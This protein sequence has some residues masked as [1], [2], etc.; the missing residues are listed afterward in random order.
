V[1]EST[2]PQGE[3]MGLGLAEVMAEFGAHSE[4]ELAPIGG[5]IEHGP[6]LARQRGLIRRRIASCAACGLRAGCSAP[7]PFEAPPGPICAVIGEAPGADED[8]RGRPF[9]GPSGK[10]LRAML[11]V[12]GIEPDEVLWANTASCRPPEN[13]APTGDEMAACRGNLMDQLDLGPRYVLL[14]GATALSAFRS[15]MKISQ[16]QGQVFVWMGKWV[17]MPILHPAA[18]LRRRELKKPTQDQ[19][20]KWSMIVKEEVEALYC[21]GDRCIRCGDVL[22][23]YDPDGVPYCST[24]F[25]R[26]GNS[27]RKERSRWE[28]K[29]QSGSLFDTGS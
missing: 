18:L 1:S 11:K 17:V 26:Y 27:W 28:T 4:V 19:L 22:D 3:D 25:P 29:P 8:R 15:D 23:H 12:A 10:L 16:V 7:V 13:R 24:H 2:D 20:A 5:S 14:V 21:L 9:V 6:A